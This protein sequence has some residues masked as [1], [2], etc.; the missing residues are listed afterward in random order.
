[1]KGLLKK[2]I[3]L[4]ESEKEELPEEQG[5][6]ETEKEEILDEI[7]RLVSKH[8]IEIDDSRLKPKPLKKDILA[9]LIINIL[10]IILLGAGI[11]SLSYFFDKR[12]ETY[13]VK[14]KT[15]LSAESK[16]I[17]TL[18]EESQRQL[19]KK[20][21]EIKKIQGRLKEIAREKETLELT[22][23]QKIKQREEMLKK[24]L[25]E[26]LKKEREK[27]L[28]RGYSEREIN[29]RL[30]ALSEKL[31]RSNEREL[32]DYKRKAEAELKKKQQ[33][34]EKLMQSYQAELLKA[35]EE[36]RRLKDFYTQKEAELK[37]KYQSEKAALEKKTQNI[38]A[39]LFK[40]KELRRR[41]NLALDQIIGI[42]K[43][44]Q[45]AIDNSDYQGA[46]QSLNELNTLLSNREIASLPAIRARKPAEEI[47]IK[48]LNELISE[49]IENKRLREYQN[50]V[51]SVDR[52][53]QSGNLYYRKK[54][55]GKAKYFYTK[56]IK[57]IPSLRGG[58]AKL[59]SILDNEF[60]QKMTTTV[61]RL[62]TE[63][64]SVINNLN[65]QISN[66]NS[67]I[68]TLNSRAQN[69]N[70][71]I[72][73]LHTEIER[74]KNNI[75]ALKKEKEE[76]E[77]RLKTIKQRLFPL[78]EQYTK[79]LDSERTLSNSQDELLNV[80]ETKVL[81]KQVLTSAEI[82]KRYPTLSNDF[83]KSFLT[84]GRINKLKGEKEAL[85]SLNNLIRYL[86][87]SNAI[88]TRHTPSKE[89][90]ENPDSL[91]TLINILRNL[92]RLLE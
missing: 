59:S 52:A 18:K 8:R 54:Q 55:Y 20:N 43:K 87:P 11:Y 31:R 61:K 2:A 39:E 40:L 81:V 29:R 42:Y 16:V 72:G 89:L 48:A 70:S 37:E 5:I 88:N 71:Q 86:N 65:S 21:M 60:N 82:K 30:K 66:L 28:G 68:E 9:P 74:L 26:T 15:L 76:R 69:L 41:E 78:I 47:T 62:K 75:A 36:Q 25:A 64:D 80:L 4:R 51:Q 22:M 3:E 90:K 45:S 10:S 83:E 12:E 35:R 49:K 92:K 84:Y 57:L 46:K 13:V 27:L 34:I 23:Q 73:I 24:Q 7:N 91:H 19:N 67:Q 1:M 44:I 58:Y 17:S 56:A 6:G 63:A 32:E 50:L 14:K 77:T 85:T 79:L 38:S 53:V 33:E